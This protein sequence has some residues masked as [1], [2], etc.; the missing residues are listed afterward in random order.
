MPK[1]VLPREEHLRNESLEYRRSVVTETMNPE[2]TMASVARQHGISV[3]TLYQWKKCCGEA[4]DS[5]DFVP[6]VLTS[7]TETAPRPIAERA[8]PR[9]HT[10]VISITMGNE[11]CV[12]FDG[13]WDLDDIVYLVRE[14]GT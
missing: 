12:S 8:K 14:I 13:A 4:G 9:L 7:E 1:T 5:A 3:S 6:I 2:A 10:G 11:S